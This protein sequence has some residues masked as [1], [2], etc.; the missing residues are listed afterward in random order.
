MKLEH[1]S[2]PHPVLG[3]RDDVSGSYQITHSVQ[4]NRDEIVISVSH[5]LLQE[6]LE[7]LISRHEAIFLTEVHCPQTLY[8]VAHTSHDPDQVIIIPAADLRDFVEI[9]FFVIADQTISPYENKEANQ[10]YSGFE[11]EVSSGDVLAYGGREHFFADKKWEA[12]KSVS[13]FMEIR[14]YSL[15]NGPMKFFL[16][17]EKII[18]NL[19]A[20]DYKGYRKLVGYDQFA[21][22]FHSSIVLPAL[23][24]AISEMIS[25]SDQYENF[26]WYKVLEAR[27]NTDEKIK[28]IPWEL[29]NVP[30]IAQI[31]LN[32]PVERSLWGMW[33]IVDQF[34]SANDD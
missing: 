20:A 26:S 16:G 11:L 22:I 25:N 24:F 9:S 31:I 5:Q 15:L 21:P 32:N 13:N 4:K 34:I 3:L 23:M 1:L 7:S 17:E 8:R 27:K 10:D 6:S 29:E 2:F 12:Q 14:P 33:K 18:V 28:S 30:E 19:P